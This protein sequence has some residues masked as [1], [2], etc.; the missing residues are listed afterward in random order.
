MKIS[1]IKNYIMYRDNIL[2]LY[3]I[4]LVIFIAHYIV[5]LILEV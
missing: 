3:N 4:T 2:S 1:A 5:F